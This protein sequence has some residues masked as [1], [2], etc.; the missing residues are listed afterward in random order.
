MHERVG[1]RVP[2]IKEVP[3]GLREREVASEGGDDGF[4][5]TNLAE[6]E[7][8]R[9]EISSRIPR[10]SYS[11]PQKGIDDLTETLCCYIRPKPSSNNMGLLAQ[12]VTMEVIG[13]RYC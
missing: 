4:R 8:R 11:F 5:G 3:A 13:R 12:P 10:R 7:S 2:A 6:E 9:E 1:E